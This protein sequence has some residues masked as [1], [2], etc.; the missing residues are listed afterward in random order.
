MQTV[1]KD[2]RHAVRLLRRDSGFAFVAVLTLAAG[3]ATVTVVFSLADAYLFRP[4][5]FDAPERLVHVWTTDPREG[6]S[7]RMSPADFR[8][9]RREA[10]S[11]EDVGGY[12]YTGMALGRDD[13][14]GSDDGR[15]RSVNVVLLTPN[16]FPVLGVE[17]LLGRTPSPE[18][19]TEGRNH[20]VVVSYRFWQR[21]LGGSE[22]ALGAPVVLDGVEHTVV[23]VMPPE[24]V[25]PFER[26]QVWAPAV[27][28]PPDESREL[29]GAA[30]LVV[31][32]LAPGADLGTAQ[33]E[34]SGIMERLADSYP[35]TNAGRGARVVPLREALLFFYDMVRTTFGVL[36]AAVL[37]VLLIICTNIGNLLLA[38]ASGRVRE[39]AVRAALG[40]GRSRLVRQ[41]LTESLLLA[42]VGGLAGIGLAALLLGALEGAMPPDLYRVG[43]V[44][45]GGRALLF[46]LAATAGSALVFGLL[47]ALQATGRDL[48]TALKNGGRSGAA[49]GAGT[50]RLR[51][52]LVVG[53]VAVA[54]LL[55]AGAGLTVRSFQELRTVQLGFEPAGLL[56]LETS[57]PSSEY[58]DGAARNRFYDRTLERIA[59]LPGVE[60]VAQIQPLPLNFESYG[61][62]FEV[63]GG[64]PLASGERPYA[65]YFKVSP[66]ALGTLGIPVLRGRDFAA[67]DDAGARP[68]ALI[69]RTLAERHFPGQDPVGR[70][71]TVDE[72]SRTVIGVV[73]D[74]K[75]FLISEDPAQVIYLPQLQT[76]TA[77]RFTLVRTAG[78]PLV[79]A[80]GV[81]GAFQE[82]SPTLPVT[83]TRTMERVVEESLGP[84][85]AG[86]AG[87]TIIGLGALLLASLGIYGVIAYSV[88]RRRREIGVRIALGAG[89]GA[90]LRLILREGV[91]LTALGTALGLT[92][93]LGLG[94]VLRAVLFGVGSFDPLTFLGAPLVLA[95]VALLATYLPAR[96][97]ARVDA[98]ETLRSE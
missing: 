33:T 53:Q 31:G 7:V 16:L 26:A 62:S 70:Q 72:T 71:I 91:G 55:L 79:L 89:R 96:A 17:P 32:R 61:T 68:V 9:L 85:L 12:Y 60:S 39:V 6:D 80:K 2:L 97:A 8:D 67:S 36:L 34:V 84:W 45:L 46:A 44:G 82:L 95:L 3:I 93:A 25:F 41:M 29:R 52:A 50:R 22:A 14:G 4:L 15:A 77:R 42:L 98:M 19:S 54:M 18:E 10:R 13:G 90:V 28:A 66:G 59:A 23:G 35:E 86:T 63:E 78:D 51:N 21:E 88:R 75:T 65:N 38:R 47:P 24:F 83:G 73:G 48:V 56:T 58:P 94:R 11:L 20:V 92:G 37:F 87:L 40:A 69:N 74:T 64:E 5:P 1:W 43:S 49:G 76:P 57:L 81:R 30:L 27:L